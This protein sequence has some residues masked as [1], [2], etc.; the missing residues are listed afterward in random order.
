M[1]EVTYEKN[2]GTR[3]SWEGETVSPLARWIGRLPVVMLR[4]SDTDWIEG[5]AG[6]R[7]RW[8]DRLLCQAFPDYLAALSDYQRA[9]AQRNALLAQP[10]YSLE[11]LS[12]WEKLLMQ[13]GT[14]IQR[15]RMELVQELQPLL[16]Q[17]YSQ[18][19]SEPVSLSYK[20]TAEPD[21]AEWLRAWERLRSQEKR[22][23]YTLLGP[24]AED[25][26]LSIEGKPA[27]H[28]ASE[29]QKK[30]LLIALKWA[31]MAYLRT[32]RSAAPLLLLDDIGEKLDSH[33]LAAVGQLSR[34]AGQTFLTDVEERR[35]REAFPELPVYRMGSSG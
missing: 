32:H 21:S 13:H 4:P 33:R 12:A 22:R 10:E 14:L 17:F 29:G 15:R 31:E 34:L 9:L 28:Y 2:Q 19:A 18:L 16:T 35:I 23:G 1:V 7:R 25:F 11:Q 30:S 20:L 6:G 24:H 3:V 26:L 27:R 8:V 5:G